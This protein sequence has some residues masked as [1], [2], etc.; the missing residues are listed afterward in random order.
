MSHGEIEERFIYRIAV[1]RLVAR[2]IAIIRIQPR[3]RETRADETLSHRITVEKHCS[4][5]IRE[6]GGVGGLAGRGRP[7]DKMA[8]LQHFGHR[9][10]LP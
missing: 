3:Q 6:T 9:D 7:A 4:D 1:C 5:F 10:S 2:R 8:G